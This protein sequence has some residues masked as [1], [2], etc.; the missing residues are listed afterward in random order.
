M[1]LHNFSSYLVFLGL[2][3][4][5]DCITFPFMLATGISYRKRQNA[6]GM[7][8]KSAEGSQGVFLIMCILCVLARQGRHL[9][10]HKAPFILDSCNWDCDITKKQVPCTSMKLLTFSDSKYNRKQ[11]QSQLLCGNGTPSWNGSFFQW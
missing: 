7:R 9:V 3:T 10:N 8:V 6:P 1:N 5:S 11:S 2:C 4:L